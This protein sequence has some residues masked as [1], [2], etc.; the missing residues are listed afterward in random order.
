MPIKKVVASMD[1][2]NESPGKIKL[3]E[4][5][6]KEI[7]LRR[8]VVIF[9]SSNQISSKYFLMSYLEELSKRYNLDNKLTCYEDGYI[10]EEKKSS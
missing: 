4:Q 7:E 3:T 1:T 8:Q 6:H 5:E 2:S 9:N 10:F